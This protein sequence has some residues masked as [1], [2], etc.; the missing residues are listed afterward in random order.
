[1]PLKLSLSC[2]VVEKNGFWAPDLYGERGE[3]I[4]QILHIHFRI[5]LTSEHVANFD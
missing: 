3:S 4:A 5:A 2:E 1:M